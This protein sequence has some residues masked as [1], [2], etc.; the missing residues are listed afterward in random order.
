LQSVINFYKLSM[1]MNNFLI[2]GSGGVIGLLMSGL[3]PMWAAPKVR[4]AHDVDER[5]P[6]IEQ[7][8]DDHERRIGYLETVAGRPTPLAP[9]PSSRHRDAT[10]PTDGY[11]VRSGDTVNGIAK[12]FGVSVQS[13]MAANRLSAKSKLQPGQVLRVPST[14]P[15]ATSRTPGSVNRYGHN[16]KNDAARTATPA[17]PETRHKVK[18]GDTVYSVARQY[19]ISE[20][21]LMRLNAIRDASRLQPGMVLRVPPSAAIRAP[22]NNA[23]ATKRDPS[24]REIDPPLPEGWRWHIVKQGESLSHVAARYGIDRRAIERVNDLRNA[25]ALQAGRKL[26]I[27][28]AEY[29]ARAFVETPK[30]RKKSVIDPDAEV[31]GYFVLKGDNLDSVAAQFATNADTIRR[32]NQMGK[33]EALVPGKRIVVPNNGIF[34]R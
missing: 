5:A 4:V 24:S 10:V 34:E 9:T 26:K 7:R 27:P 16:E 11:R 3:Q 30:T 22:A 6:A 18:K 28:T 29:A 32:L 13:L 12:R 2:K 23:A 21:E 31:L 33:N 1:F 20:N 8:V 25:S 14:E 17:K 19:G 15:A